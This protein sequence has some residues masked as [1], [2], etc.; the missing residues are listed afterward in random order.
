MTVTKQNC[1]REEIG[2]CLL[3]LSSEYFVLPSPF[4]K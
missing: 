1:I 2:K 4:Y 3:P